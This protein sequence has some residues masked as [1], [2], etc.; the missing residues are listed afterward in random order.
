[1]LAVDAVGGDAAVAPPSA[2]QLV[3]KVPGC[4]WFGWVP[5]LV[6]PIRMFAGAAGAEVLVAGVCTVKRGRRGG[7]LDALL[8]ELLPWRLSVAVVV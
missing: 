2:C 1:V 8:L 4:R 6:L 5:E 7:R 3:R